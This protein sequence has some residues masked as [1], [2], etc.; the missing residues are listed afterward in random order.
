MRG[1]ARSELLAAFG[2]SPSGGRHDAVVDAALDEIAVA[3]E[4]ALDIDAILNIA[5]SRS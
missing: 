1:E 3:L 4:A 2:G 5:A